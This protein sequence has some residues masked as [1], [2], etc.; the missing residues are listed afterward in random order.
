MSGRTG[1]IALATAAAMAVLV[2]AA[3]AVA[4]TV[5]DGDGGGT[6]GPSAP[7][8]PAGQPT[9]PFTGLPGGADAPVLAVKIDNVGAARPQTGLTRADIVY[10]E[11]VEAGLSRILAIFSTRL[12]PDRVGPVR[13]ARESDLELLRQFGRPAL[14]YS[15]AQSKL[16]PLI[17]RAPVYDVSPARAP[18]AYARDGSRP[19]PHNLY[20]DPARL[21]ARA[22]DAS[23]ARDV[24]FRFGAAPA[25]GTPGADHTDHTVRYGAATI[26]LRWSP[27]QDRWL[28]SFDGTP[29]TSTEGGHLGAP[30][31]VIQYVTVRPSRFKDRGGNVSPYSETVGSGSALVLRDGAT[32][33]A[34]WSRPAAEA[35]T[36]FTTRAG[37]PMTF[38]P[39]PVWIVFAPRA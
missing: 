2:A 27:A 18:G 14:A 1:R 26:R 8:S 5:R 21:L 39:G 17:A 16:L 25:G 3:I 34:R 36:T 4:L 28:V 24:G 7:G 20:G 23:E 30:T 32:Y 33:Q 11:P 29:A 15:G 31:V 6:V 35:G 12:P 22:R 19:A 37:A 10:V 38:H 13:S 9:S